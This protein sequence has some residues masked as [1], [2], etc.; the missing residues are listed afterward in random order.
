MKA[1][2]FVTPAVLVLVAAGGSARAEGVAG[3][4]TIMVQAG[5]QSEV[6]G[7][8]IAAASGTVAGKPVTITEKRYKALYGASA[9]LRLQAAVGYGIAPKVELFARGAYYE[10]KVSA[11]ELGTFDGHPMF[12]CFEPPGGS[13]GTG[14]GALKTTEW[15]AEAGLRFYIAPQS[16]LKSYLAA[17]GGVRHNDELLVS[18][19]A[20]EAGAAVLHVPFSQGGTVAVFGAD[21]GVLF[22]ITPGFFVGVDTGIRW[23]QGPN[24]FGALPSMAGWDAHS[25]R[26]TSPV[27]GTLGVRF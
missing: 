26:W 12:G 11:V 13:T 22:D 24:G 16:R 10:P 6:S 21:L 18:F 25:G 5:T 23:Q 7:T 1:R 20:P 27:V 2:R 19:S 9:A 4:F 14:C 8:A 17:V 3:K 15:G